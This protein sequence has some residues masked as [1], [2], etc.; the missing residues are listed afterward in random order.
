M[1]SLL[2]PMDKRGK[3]GYQLTFWLSGNCYFIIV[4][5]YVFTVFLRANGIPYMQPLSPNSRRSQIA[6]HIEFDYLFLTICYQIIGNLQ[7]AAK[8]F[9]AN[10]GRK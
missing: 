3:D 7:I 2:L 6:P 8:F 1:T 5:D 10:S 9:S 4:G